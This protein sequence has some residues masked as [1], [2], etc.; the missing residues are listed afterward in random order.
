MLYSPAAAVAIM[1]TWMRRV[2]QV[3]ALK[4]EEVRW[5]AMLRCHWLGLYVDV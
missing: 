2:L 1:S 3:G 5:L 4:A